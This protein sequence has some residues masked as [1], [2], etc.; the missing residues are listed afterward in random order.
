M[1]SPRA[2]LLLGPTASGKT[3]LSL[4]LAT[5]FPIEIISVDSA[6]VYRG[7]DIGTAKPTLKERSICQHHLIDIREISESYSAADFSEDATRLIKEILSR[8]HIPLIVGGTMLYAKA[9]REGM[10]DLPP[11]DPAVREEV[12]RELHERGLPALREELRKVDPA[13]VERLTEGD[14]QRIARALEV[15]RMTGRAISEFQ[16]GARTPDSTLQVVGLMPSDRSRLHADIGRRFDAMLQE[17]FLEEMRTLMAREDFSKELPSMRSV[18]Y[19]QAIDY[20]ESRTDKTQFIEAAKAATRQLAKR[21]MT[22]LRSMPEVTL[23]DPHTES[24]DNFV[25]KV[26]PVVEEIAEGLL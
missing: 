14:T 1:A 22:W 17:G 2:L 15:Y 11:T 20:L 25:S 7:M 19:R 3:A 24:P 13:C 9:L 23:F 18:G 6:L 5:K 26:A 16:K 21:Q 8:R 12:L 10:D 4:Q